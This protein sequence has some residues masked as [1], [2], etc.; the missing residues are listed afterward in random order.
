LWFSCRNN[1]LFENNK[2]VVS[3]C[4]S[5]RWMSF[6]D[7]YSKVSVWHVRSVNSLS[8]V[9]DIRF[10]LQKLYLMIYDLRFF[11]TKQLTF[12]RPSLLY[13]IYY[14]LLM[15]VFLKL[16][17]YTHILGY[18]AKYK[19]VDR[20]RQTWCSKNSRIG[21][22]VSANFPVFSLWAKN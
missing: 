17:N 9:V 14:S 15:N 7:E 2:Y 4:D 21:C 3:F 22:V 20:S 8:C 18:T 16:G 1:K 12:L 5:C 11:L 19:F 10:R 13:T 6:T